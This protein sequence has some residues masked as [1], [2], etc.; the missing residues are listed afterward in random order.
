MVLRGSDYLGERF[1]LD[2]VADLARESAGTDARG[3]RSEFVELV[4]VARKLGAG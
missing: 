2:E 4:D 1:G 3:Y